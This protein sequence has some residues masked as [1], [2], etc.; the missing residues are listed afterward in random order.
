MLYIFDNVTDKMDFVTVI[1]YA[2]ESPSDHKFIFAGKEKAF[3][4]KLMLHNKIRSN[5]ITYYPE[6]DQKYKE[7][8]NTKL[9]FVSDFK[10]CMSNL[11]KEKYYIYGTTPHKSK[12]NNIFEVKLKKKVHLYL[13]L[14][15]DYP[16]TN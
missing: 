2:L 6:L 9:F 3:Y 14:K 5:L 11:K 1:L 7:L 4:D 13:V 16:K 12:S 15:M 8:V 10:T